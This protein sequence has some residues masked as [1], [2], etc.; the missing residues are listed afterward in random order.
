MHLVYRPDTLGGPGLYSEESPLCVTGQW[1][2]RDQGWVLTLEC[3]DRA[4][5]ALQTSVCQQLASWTSGW[6]MEGRRPDVMPGLGERHIGGTAAG[7]L[8]A[9]FVS[10]GRMLEGKWSCWVGRFIPEERDGS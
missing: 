4:G 3:V 7:Q 6:S 2:V 8:W 10:V 1:A 9:S 5:C